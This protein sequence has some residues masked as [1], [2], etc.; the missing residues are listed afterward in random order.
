MR[1]SVYVVVSTVVFNTRPGGQQFCRIY[2]I[3]VLGNRE[4]EL[5]AATRQSCLCPY[6][7]P[8]MLSYGLSRS[9]YCYFLITLGLM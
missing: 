7:A 6:T 4:A 8:P 1:L 2:D 9:D 5:E 3:T